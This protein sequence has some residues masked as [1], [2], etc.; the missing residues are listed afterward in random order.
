MYISYPKLIQGFSEMK[1]ISPHNKK[2]QKKKELFEWN[3]GVRTHL[4]LIFTAILGQMHKKMPVPLNTVGST[5]FTRFL[6]NIMGH[7]PWQ[8]TLH[9]NQSVSKPDDS[10]MD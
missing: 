3:K 9:L 5:V 8:G 4:F 1:G 7:S 10:S 2:G 6:C